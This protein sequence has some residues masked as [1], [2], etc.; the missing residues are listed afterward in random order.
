VARQGLTKSFE[1][2]CCCAKEVIGHASGRLGLN[3]LTHV[4]SNSTPHVTSQ[5]TTSVTSD[6]AFVLKFVSSQT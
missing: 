5:V 2:R 1:R 3:A 4:L 6:L